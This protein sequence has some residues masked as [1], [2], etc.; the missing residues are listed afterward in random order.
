LKVFASG[1]IPRSRMSLALPLDVKAM[2][3][4]LEQVMKQLSKLVDVIK[5]VELKSED[6]VARELALSQGQG[7]NS[8][9]V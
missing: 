4:I 1:V 6:S 9:Q 2:P 5:I 7:R 8:P 3:K